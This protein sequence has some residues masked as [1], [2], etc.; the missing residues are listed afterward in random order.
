MLGAGVRGDD[1]SRGIANDGDQKIG[2]ST[3][4][5][6]S[7]AAGSTTGA[8]RNKHDDALASDIDKLSITSAEGSSSSKR[9]P[10]QC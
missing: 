5:S 1:S 2:V 10:R 9:D 6:S 7:T 4:D 8:A 3:H